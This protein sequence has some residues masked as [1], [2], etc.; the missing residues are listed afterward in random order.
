MVDLYGLSERLALWLFGGLHGL[1]SP[2]KSLPLG[3]GS[4]AGPQ[5]DLLVNPG[6]VRFNAIMIAA[7]VLMI[8]VPLL[9]LLVMVWFERKLLGRIWDRRSIMHH[10]PLGFLQNVADGVKMLQKELLIPDKADRFLYNV[11]PTIMVAS[12]LMIL[13]FIPYSPGF[14]LASQPLTAVSN[15]AARVPDV[16]LLFVIALLGLTPPAVLM[17]GWACNNKYTLLGGMRA[18]AQTMSYEVPL[19]LS[20]AGPVI[21]A[22]TLNPIEIVQV[23]QASIWFIVPQFLGFGIFF[24]AMF[25]E[26]ERIPFD[27][28]EAPGELVEGWRTEY[29]GIR[30][31]LIMLVDYVK[32][33][34]AAAVVALV[35]FGG[36]DGPFLP[37]EIWMLAKIYL[38]FFVFVWVRAT[39]PRIRVDQLLD[40]G[41]KKL[42]PLALV[43]IIIAVFMKTAGWF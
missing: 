20:L 17:A 31:A 21:L 41:W 29:G 25:A 13:A 26:M 22:G 43:N 39:L 5:I 32:A 12:S 7:T 1:L 9:N 19:V 24:V 33:W 35:F 37:P 36:W 27:I 10:G 6:F 18:A 38:I 23:Q 8:F 15:A 11:A 2:L 3:I 14:V 16:G 30:F 40:I 42:M 34:V 4:V 28:P